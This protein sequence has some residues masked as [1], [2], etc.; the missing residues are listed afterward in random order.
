MDNVNVLGVN[1]H[2]LTMAEAVD[3]AMGFLDMAD[4]TRICVTPGPEIVMRA[5]DSADF[6]GL[7]NS[8]DMCVAD[9]VGIIW[10]AKKLGK[11]LPERVSGI[12]LVQNLFPLMAENGR[13]VYFFGGAPG[14]AAA[15][16]NAVKQAHPGLKIAGARDGF[17]DE[18]QSGEI[19]AE[20]NNAAPDLLLVALGSP[21]QERWIFANAND[22]QSRLAIGV[23]GT[24]DVLSGK[25]NRAPK[26]FRKLGLEWFYRLIR[27]PSRATRQLR[28]IHFAMAVKTFKRLNH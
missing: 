12:D 8:A 14:V 15:A 22:L 13:S 28:L 1:F 27:Q 24:L 21:K 16:A 19:V 20:I 11:P 18:N 3:K 26:I 7:L 10:A 25:L 6:M 5:R 23:G 4:K 9:G 17:F 2:M